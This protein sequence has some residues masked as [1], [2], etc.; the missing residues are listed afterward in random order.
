MSATRPR[1]RRAPTTK[2]ID[3]TRDNTKIES[4]LRQTQRLPH[5]LRHFRRPISAMDFDA[6]VSGC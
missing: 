6:E 3:N 5:T 1:S 4:G 2:K